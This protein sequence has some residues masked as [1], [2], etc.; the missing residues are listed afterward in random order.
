[1]CAFVYVA[2]VPG[3]R[4]TLSQVRQPCEVLP[5]QARPKEGCKHGRLVVPHISLA[6]F[7]VSRSCTCIHVDRGQMAGGAF[8]GIQSWPWS[9][10]FFHVPLIPPPV[11]DARGS[12]LANSLAVLALLLTPLPCH[13]TGPMPCNLGG[14]RSFPSFN[15]RR[16]EESI[17]WGQSNPWID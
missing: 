12:L 3:A 7:F 16:P 14:E 4:P 1:V 9:S 10:P 5:E 13:A 8:Q 11:Q 6:A 17:Q 15:D 2:M